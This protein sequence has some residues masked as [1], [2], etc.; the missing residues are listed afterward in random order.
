MNDKK[1]TLSSYQKRIN[2]MVIYI[3]EHLDENPSLE[4]LSEEAG[5]SPY[6]FHRIAK[7]F[8]GE[9]IGNFIVRKR[10]ETAAR[11]LKETDLPVSEIAYQVGY[12]VPSSLS[13]A[14]KLFYGMTPN[15]YRKNKINLIMEDVKHNPTLKLEERVEVIKPKKAI[16]FSMC[17]DYLTCDYPKGF[18]LLMEYAAKKKLNLAGAEFLAIYYDDP[19]VTE[20]GKQH[21]DVCLATSE[22]LE[23]TDSLKVKEIAGG[24]Y[25]IYLYKGTYKKLGSVYDTVF[26]KYIPE[27]NF[28][29][30]DRPI[31]EVYL[32]DAAV[33]K[34]ED[35]L[36]ELYIPVR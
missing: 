2:R 4:T 31:F 12:D 29:V 16:C 8:L 3:T 25:A 21:A 10:V 28:E 20:S 24:K 32:N 26:R 22:P 36:T 14:F 35:L 13:K 18:A 6:H 30:D 33:T 19:C 34:P 5:F 9:T 27:G 1:T 15:E 7:A 17:G 11:L 23:A